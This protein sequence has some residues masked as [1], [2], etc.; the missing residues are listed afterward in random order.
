ME[1]HFT[2]ILSGRGQIFL[3]CLKKQKSIVKNMKN[4]LYLGCGGGEEGAI[5]N[6]MELREET[7]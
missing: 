2:D 6:V 7:L 1:I 4:A 5:N 3:T